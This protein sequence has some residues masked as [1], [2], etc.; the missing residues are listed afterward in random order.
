MKGDDKILLK[1]L[2]GSDKKLFI[3]V[4]QRNYDWKKENCELLFHDLVK[5]IKNDKKS[6]F[7]GSIVTAHQYDGGG[8]SFIIID[9]QQRIT[10]VSLLFLAMINAVKNGEAKTE[11]ER[12]CDKIMKS[13]IIDEY[14]TDRIKVRLKPT[15]GDNEAFLKIVVNDKDN[16][17]EDSNVTKNYHILYDMVTTMPFS[18]DQMYEAIKKLVIID[19]YVE[20]DDDPQLIFESLNST[21]LKLTKA[22]MIRNYVLMGLD[23]KQQLEFYNK[24]WCPIE[25]NVERTKTAN[26]FRDYLTVKQHKIPSIENVYNVFK[27]YAEGKEIELI[28]KDLLKY[29]RIYHKILT[30]S[31]ENPEANDI[32]MRLNILELTVSY[33]YLMSLFEY[34]E[35]GNIND[36]ELK[37]VLRC[38]ESYVFRRLV[39]NYPTNALNKIFCTLH[40]EA[41]KAMASKNSYSS[42]VIYL[43]Q[44]KTRSSIFPR[45]EAFKPLFATKDIYSMQKRSKLYIFDRLENQ[46]S[47]ETTNLID[48]IN[49]GTYSIEHIMPQT[50]N[51]EWKE[52]LGENNESIHQEWLNTI[53]NLTITGYNSKYQNRSFT[54]KKTIENG[55]NDSPLRLNQYLKSCTKWTELEMKERLAQLQTLALKLWPFPSTDYLPEKKT[56]KEFN[57]AEEYD[58]KNS[59]LK[60]YIFMGTLYPTKGWTDMIVSVVKSLHELDSDILENMASHN[61]SIYISDKPRLKSGRWN[62]VAESVFLNTNSNT[63]TKIRFLRDIFDEYDLDQSELRFVLYGEE[64]KNMLFS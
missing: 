56:E 44:I 59:K 2:D 9:G 16:F 30:S 60:Q 24:Y 35:M 22:D 25:K 23:A 20:D 33:P 34:Y 36:A 21:G 38:I 51:K 49:N 47:R 40:G 13:Y 46:D 45:D 10:T 58:Y 7:F 41:V 54:E 11:N 5:L 14:S 26:F 12:V 1:V 52:E 15:K 50:L 48:K 32:L 6:H 17:I 53:A 42:S 55:Y 28:L 61:Q 64:D 39:C 19:I 18:I 27:E 63:T 31:L 29:S 57:L 8:D 37:N 4:Y 43:L 3:P 62:K